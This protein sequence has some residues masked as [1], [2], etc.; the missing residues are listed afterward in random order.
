[1]KKRPTPET[2][3]KI[4]KNEE[5]MQMRGKLKIFLGASPGVGKTYTMLEEGLEKRAQGLDVVIGVVESHGRKEI[6]AL[7][8][9]FEVM[10][11]VTI[12]YHEKEFLEF[13]LDS[14]I[15]RSPA[16]IL[17][18]ELA[19]TNIPGLRH[20]KRFRDIEEILDHGI[21]VYTTLNV[22]HIESLN[23]T[24]TQIIGVK[25][26]EIVPDSILELADTVEIVDLPPEDL[27]K[28]LER[29]EVYF[30]EQAKIAKENFFKK[31]NLI[32]L[33]ELALRVTAECVGTQTYLYR[34]DLGIRQ[35]WPIKEK[36]LVCVGGSENSVKIIRQAK[37]LATHL[38]A[39][40]IA[41]YVDQVR[42]K[43]S[44]KYRDEAI[45]NL[46]LAE[47]LG[48]KSKILT[49]FDIVK[50]V[51]NFARDENA[52]QI[53]IGKRV[54]PRWKDIFYRR[55]ADEI[56][57][58]SQEIDV[59]IMSLTEQGPDKKLQ[60]KDKQPTPWRV[61]AI[62]VSMV[63]A[64]SIVNFFISPYLDSSNLIMMY[65]LVVTIVALFGEIGPSILCSLLSVLAYDVFFVSPYNSFKVSGIAY[66]MTMLIMLLVA[67]IIS[68]LTL[69][70]KQQAKAAK[71][72]EQQI[73]SLHTLSHQLARMRG[74]KR[75]LEAGI[76]HLSEQL[77]SKIIGLFPKNEKF[78]I[79]NETCCEQSIDEKEEGVIKWVYDSGQMA[80]TETDNLPFLKALYFPL[81]G[82]NHAIGVLRIVPNDPK[83]KFSQDEINILQVSAH[84][85]AIS[86]EVDR[87]QQQ[88]IKAKLASKK[89]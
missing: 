46:H 60:N 30:P 78:V 13:D 15:K 22:Q 68:Y 37:R 44:E 41:V 20:V 53:I 18:D 87:L 66:L 64:V 26:S 56:V 67:N 6:K 5:R 29:G 28:R 24:I 84:Q 69:L 34:Q 63:V 47:Q 40:W 23:G 61:Y 74:V 42:I 12:N 49:G 55:L 75:L 86:I 50:E 57:R 52:T 73:T 62:S 51:M 8:E 48:A 76:S 1:M 3:L 70:T 89:E 33:R 11:R 88:K 14:A 80:G 27:L 9:K 10:P 4:A 2:M 45:K 85:I 43:K 21:D 81:L 31:G 17:I 54:R 7:T 79:L 83:R 58:S 82:F 65:L 59:Y 25:I 16:L 32:A 77:D 36:I 72:S 35:I 38:R 19:H 71:F 39:E